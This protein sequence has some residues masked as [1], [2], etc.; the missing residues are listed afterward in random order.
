MLIVVSGLSWPELRGNILETNR[1]DC[2]QNF[3]NHI[4]L[5]SVSSALFQHRKFVKRM[6]NFQV[7]AN[8]GSSEESAALPLRRER[9]KADSFYV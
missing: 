4:C 6:T 3:T 7:T 5:Q 9:G 1:H 8:Q 2:L